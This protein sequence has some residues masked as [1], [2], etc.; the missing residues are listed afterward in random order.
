MAQGSNVAGAT[1]Q[2]FTSAFN[3]MGDGL[4]T[5]VTTGKLNFK[6]FTASIVSDLAKISARM[7]MMQAVKESDLLWD[8]V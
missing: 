7:A 1:E 2:M 4:A 3:S 6:S 5:F 8:L